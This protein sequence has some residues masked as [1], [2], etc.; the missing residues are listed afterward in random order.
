MIG[1]RATVVVA[2]LAM[3]G[4][5]GCAGVSATKPTPSPTVA[6]S[7]QQR[8]AVSDGV[9]TLDEYRAGFDRYQAC[10]ARAGF[11]LV[12]PHLDEHDLMDSGVPDAAVRSG[13]DEK[14]YRY[15]WEAVDT[16]WQIAHEDSSESAQI[17]RACLESK[18][19]DPRDAYADNL[20]LMQELG[21]DITECGA[22]G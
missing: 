2:L 7:K 10:L 22:V 5:S 11:E 1:H 6:Q 12:D 13:V 18:G 20:D 19:V 4:L 16:L 9:V 15:N 14:C 3:A 21:I 8:A 17:V